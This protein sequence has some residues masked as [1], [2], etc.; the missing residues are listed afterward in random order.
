MFWNE[1]SDINVHHVEKH[2]F[3]GLA[4]EK[5]NYIVKR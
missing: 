3:I 4:E 5:K 2:Y 1:P